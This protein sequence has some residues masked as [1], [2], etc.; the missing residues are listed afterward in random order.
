MKN[1]KHL[2]V[3]YC[4]N[5]EEIDF[6]INHKDTINKLF[7]NNGSKIIYICNDNLNA[8]ENF[9]KVSID[10]HDTVNRQP[11]YSN[12]RLEKFLSKNVS[13]SEKKISKY[14]LIKNKLYHKYINFLL[15]CRRIGKRILKNHGQRY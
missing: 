10:K 13:I 15:F 7:E 8:P 5:Q 2:F 3:R 11:F 9:Y 12:S 1:G 4:A 14:T 6:I